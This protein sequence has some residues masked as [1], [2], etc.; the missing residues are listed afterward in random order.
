MDY[1][2]V[3]K[4]Y[5]NEGLNEND[6]SENP[7]DQ[8]RLWVQEATERAPGRWL[9]PN[10]MTLSTSDQHG[11]VTSRVVLLKGIRDDGFCFFTNYESEKGRQMAANPNVS[12]L[13]HWPYLGRQLRIVGTV[14]K[15]SREDSVSYFHSRPRGSQI[16]AAVSAQSDPIESRAELEQLAEDLTRQLGGAEVPCPDHWGGYIVCPSSIEFWQGRTNRLHDRIAFRRDNSGKW[17]QHRLCP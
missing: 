2:A 6:L 15:G 3:R 11:H 4:E 8:V 9:E 10:A 5:E 17:N 12:L 7:I 14:T 16:G 1:Q 13:F